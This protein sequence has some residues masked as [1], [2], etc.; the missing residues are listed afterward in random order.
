MLISG[1]IFFMD[2]LDDMMKTTE[3]KDRLL[4]FLEHFCKDIKSIGTEVIYLIMV[5]CEILNV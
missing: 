1:T 2:N 4:R 5:S 3:K